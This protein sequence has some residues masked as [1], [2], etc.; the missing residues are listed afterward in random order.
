MNQND[1]LSKRKPVSSFR[2]NEKRLF[3]TYSQTDINREDILPQLTT[4]LEN[5]IKE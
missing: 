4:I 1:N 2:L 5:N 3:L